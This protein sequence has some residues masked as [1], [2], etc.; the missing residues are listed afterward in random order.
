VLRT[1]NAVHGNKSLTAA[2]L[3]RNAAYVVTG[4]GTAVERRQIPALPI[5]LTLRNLLQSTSN[6]LIFAVGRFAPFEFD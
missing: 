6:A 5:P 2:T 1:S 3:H 4:F